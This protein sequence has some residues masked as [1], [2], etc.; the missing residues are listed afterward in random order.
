LIP[1]WLRG[2]SVDESLLKLDD[3]T[4][5]ER[6]NRKGKLTDSWRVNFPES[7]REK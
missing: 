3:E 2:R 6:R 4:A 1:E 7:E 5:K